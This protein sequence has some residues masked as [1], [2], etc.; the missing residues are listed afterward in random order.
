MDRLRPERVPRQRVQKVWRNVTWADAFSDDS[1]IM[2]TIDITP[3][4]ALRKIALL[5]ENKKYEECAALVRK[6]NELAV[7]AILSEVPI[8]VLHESLPQSLCI[9]EALYLKVFQTCT[10]NFPLEQMCTEQLI[11]RIVCLFA[12]EVHMNIKGAKNCNMFLP[13]CRTIL[14]IVMTVEPQFKHHIVQRKKVLDHCLKRLGKH[15]MVDTS[16]GK[17]MNLHDAL[18]VEFEKVVVQYKYAIQKLE[19]LSLTTKHPTSTSLTSGKAPICA[20]HQRLMQVTRSDVQNRV[21][22]NK[23][24]YTVVEPVIKNQ[25]LTSL[26]KTLQKRIEY[27]K[28]T[29]F[30]DTELRKMAGL[31][32]DDTYLSVT[33][34]Q[35]SQ[36]YTTM[37]QLLRE[38]TGDDAADDE[39][40]SG[41]VSSS[42]DDVDTEMSSHTLDEKI[43]SMNGILP[44]RPQSD[45]VDLSGILSMRSMIDVVHVNGAHSDEAASASNT[46]VLHQ[47]GVGGA[48]L[49]QRGQTP[50]KTKYHLPNGTESTTDIRGDA[51]L[52]GIMRSTGIAHNHRPD[53]PSSNPPPV[54]MATSGDDSEGLRAEI[55]R[56]REELTAS[57]EEIRR[58]LHREQTLKERLSSNICTQF[59]LNNGNFENLSLGDKRP[60]ELIHKYGNLYTDG[61]MDAMDALDRLQELTNLDILKMK[62]LFSVIVLC[63]RSVQQSIQELRGRLRHLLNLP[64][65]HSGEEE[66]DTDKVSSEMEKHIT[67][68]LQQT[69]DRCDLST[70]VQEVCAQIYAT[71]FDYPCLKSC[72]ALVDYIRECLSLAWG[73]SVQKTPF[74]IVYDSRTFTEDLHNRF[75]TSDPEENRIQCFLWPC[76]MEG[77]NGSCVH[78]GVVIT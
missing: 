57:K 59:N 8:E 4:F 19:H 60:S 63:F 37:L 44:T 41:I 39:A 49:K 74:V 35:F 5:F 20:S 2:D 54:C 18:K 78:K 28:V 25:Y 61:R 7:E 45:G 67:L 68:Y 43:V 62:I 56:L 70:N 26:I 51:M 22:K 65:P 15:G 33:L 27:D 14:R 77:H 50:G 52:P 66:E 55:H 10:T 40:D 23:T 29:L 71:L 11:T 42:D 38:V 47:S 75:H 3:N 46:R 36:G 72:P 30:H 13:S 16:G 34:R 73:L 6:L 64:V 17:F 58:L 76:L 32:D 1:L 31:T 9:L 48:S 12:K 24:L 69:T 21:I 53:K